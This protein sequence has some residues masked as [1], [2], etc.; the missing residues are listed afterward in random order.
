MSQIL[1]RADSS[2]N[3]TGLQTGARASRPAAQRDVLQ[4]HQQ[5]FA[6][7]VG[8]RIV[9]T[10]WIPRDWIAIPDDVRQI[11][12]ELFDQMISQRTDVFA[13]ILQ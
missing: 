8:E 4:G 3:V 1:G 12:L 11:R 13:I 7:D 6:L 9:N 2:Q 10:T 5:R